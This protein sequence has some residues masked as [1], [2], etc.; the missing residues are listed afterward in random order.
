MDSTIF[1]RWTSPFQILGV[2]GG[3]FYF[4]QVW[5]IPIILYANSEDADRTPRVA[6]S[7]QGL[8]CLPISPKIRHCAYKGLLQSKNPKLNWFECNIVQNEI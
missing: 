6:A 8:H 7:D 4:I 5:C 1:I 2:L 3:I